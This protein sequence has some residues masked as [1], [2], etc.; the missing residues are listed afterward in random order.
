MYSMISKLFWFYHPDD[1][2]MFDT[3]AR[4]GL[5]IDA[6]VKY[7]DTSHQKFVGLFEKRFIQ[8]KWHITYAKNCFQ[9]KYPYDRRIFDKYLWLEGCDNKEEIIR[10]FRKSLEILRH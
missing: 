5:M 10:N 8:H 3:L 7:V 4:R 1:L 6:N 9:R 2:T